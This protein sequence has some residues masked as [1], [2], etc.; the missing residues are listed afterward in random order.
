M[1]VGL[2][3]VPASVYRCRHSL[4]PHFHNLPTAAGATMSSSLNVKG[5]FCL[6]YLWDN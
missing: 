4:Q 2:E 3:R 6:T 5:K 1:K